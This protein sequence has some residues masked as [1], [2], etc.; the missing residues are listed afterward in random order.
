MIEHYVAYIPSDPAAAAHAAIWKADLSRGTLELLRP[1]GGMWTYV[2]PHAA[3][4]I[5]SGER[6]DTAIRRVMS[7]GPARSLQYTLGRLSC[8]PGEYFHRIARPVW[9]SHLEGT[10]T[11]W[12]D[13]ELLV[14]SQIGGQLDWLLEQLRSIC[15]TVHPSR[16]TFSTFGH[17]I[18]NLLILAC[19]EVEAAWKGVL[20]TNGVQRK[21]FTTS[22]YVKLCSV[23]HLTEYSIYFRPYPWLEPMRPFERWHDGAPSQSIPWYFAYNETKHDRENKFSEATLEHAFHAVAACV[24]MLHAQFGNLQGSRAD[25]SVVVL[26]RP[27]WTLADCYIP[28]NQIGQTT[29]PKAICYKF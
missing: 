26:G 15:Q 13:H 2:G 14:R 8:A 23:L 11:N 28:S 22:D 7:T 4:S 29:S 27:T 6:A 5:G 20:T 17:E 1:W 3:E 10:I 24:V 16:G 19:T 12:D 18:R 25:H 21:Q 9:G